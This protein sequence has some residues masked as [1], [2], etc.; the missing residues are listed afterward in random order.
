MF[1]AVD[2]LAICCR[3]VGKLADWYCNTLG[4][5]LIGRHPTSTSVV[6]GYDASTRGGAMLELIEQ[7]DD[8]PAP[9][10]VPSFAPGVRHF[11][12]RVDNFDAAHAELKSRGIKFFGEPGVATGGGKIASFRDPEGNEVQIV[13]R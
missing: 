13:Q 12:L 3:D 7:K 2:H 6:V 9:V 8:G 11:A 10:E 5:R 4:M 1:I